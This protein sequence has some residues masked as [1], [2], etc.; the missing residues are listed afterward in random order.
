MTKQ[1]QISKLNQEIAELAGLASDAS[2]VRL[3]NLIEKVRLL[4]GESARR[5]L[6]NYRY[7]E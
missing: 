6:P 3:N 7:G 4:Q 2:Q 5:E 1:E